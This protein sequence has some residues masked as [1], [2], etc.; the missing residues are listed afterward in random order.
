MPAD[1]PLVAFPLIL[2][3]RQDFWSLPLFFPDLKVGVLWQWPAGIPYQ[4][5]PLPPEAAAGGPGLSHYAPGELKQ[6]QAY[7]EYSSSREEFG[8]ILRALR[9]EPAEPQ[10]TEGPW[11]DQDP[12]SLAWQLEVMEA[13]QEAHLAQVDRGDEWLGQ[14]L[15]PEETWEETGSL[16]AAPEDIEVLD[17]ATAR[18]RYLLWRREM[19]GLL[20]PE[21]MPLLLGRT[22]R[23]TFTSLRREAGGGRAQR[24]RVRLSGCRTEEEYQAA[25]TAAAETGWQQEFRQRL[26]VCLLAAESS[27]DLEPSAGELNNWL[28]QEL[29]RLWPELPSW[30]WELEIWGREPEVPEAGEALLAWGGLGKAVV[31]G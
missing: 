8:D 2:P 13:D 4:G 15:T 19:G 22:S 30:T 28:A 1:R 20:G 17:P 24:A 10:V 5:R 31:P 6:W 11:K 25:Q 27:G 14:M 29:P 12:L 16:T 3:W 21:S 23:T 9:G 7:E 18:L 26:G